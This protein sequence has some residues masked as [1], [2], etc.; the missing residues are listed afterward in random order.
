MNNQPTLQTSRLL[1]RPFALED[2]ARVQFLAGDARIA[3]VTAN[4][5]HPYLDGIAERWIATHQENW[6]RGELAAFAVTQ[7][8]S[9]LL[10]G[11]ISIMRCNQE[12]EIGYWIGVEYW[13]NGYATE[14]CLAITDFATSALT[15]TRLCA[16]HLSRNPASGRVLVKAGFT[17]VGA[18]ALVIDSNT[19]QDMLEIYEMFPAPKIQTA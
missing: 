3:A 17:H 14:A 11:C 7:K 12:P 16:R 9:G 5:P 2:A 6:E 4:V 15:L 18:Q 1:L 13:N 8:E 19:R 10:I